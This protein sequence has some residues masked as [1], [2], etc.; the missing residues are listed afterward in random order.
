MVESAHNQDLRLSKFSLQEYPWLRE[1][2]KPS[3]FEAGFLSSECFP[4]TLFVIIEIQFRSLEF[5]WLVCESYFIVDLPFGLLHS[6][7]GFFSIFSFLNNFSLRCSFILFFIID[8]KSFRLHD[9]TVPTWVAWGKWQTYTWKCPKLARYAW[10]SLLVHD[11]SQ[12]FDRGDWWTEVGQV[13]Y[14][15]EKFCPWKTSKQ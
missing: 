8:F 6:V 14:L 10:L 12:G 3:I 4:L 5:F 1:F 11:A 9:A 7:F 13:R 2:V 15:P